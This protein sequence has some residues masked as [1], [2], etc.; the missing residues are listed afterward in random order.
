MGDV[1]SLA[2]VFMEMILLK[3]LFAARSNTHLFEL[4]QKLLGQL[5]KSERKKLKSGCIVGEAVRPKHP[6]F[7]NVLCRRKNFPTNLYLSDLLMS[8]FQWDP[9][10]R[11]CT[12]DSLRHPYF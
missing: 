11:I 6:S 8:M 4:H 1:W 5:S 2:C 10:L 7:V 12:Q 9:Q 3:P